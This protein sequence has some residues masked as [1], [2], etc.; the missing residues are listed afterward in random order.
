MLGLFGLVSFLAEQR[1]KEIGIR[2]VNGAGNGEILV[3]MN[4]IFLKWVVIAFLISCPIAWYAVR[5]WLQEFAYRTSIS[6]AVFL[7]AGLLAMIIALITV[8]WQS[9]RAAVKNPV[10]SLRYE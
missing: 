10:E 1:R 9:W 4:R 7:L 5:A 8:S 2:K 3:M 6:P